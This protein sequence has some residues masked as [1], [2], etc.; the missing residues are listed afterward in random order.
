MRSTPTRAVWLTLALSVPI[1]AWADGI[2]SAIAENQNGFTLTAIHGPVDEDFTHNVVHGAD[3]PTTL[4]IAEVNGI[5]TSDRLKF[6]GASHHFNPPHGEGPNPNSF[7]MN[8][9]LNSGNYKGGVTRSTLQWAIMEHNGNGNR[10][11]DSYWLAYVVNVS[12]GVALND[13]DGYTVIVRGVHTSN[14]IF[15]PDYTFETFLSGA[16]QVPP[17]QS[18]A[19]GLAILETDPLF[20]T[21]RLSMAVSGLRVQDVTA[22]HIHQGASGQNGGVVF[23]LLGL[24]Q[25]FPVGDAGF[26]FVIES[27]ALPPHVN[28]LIRNR[29]AYINVH[30]ARFPGGEVR[31]D[32]VLTK[33]VRRV[34]R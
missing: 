17:V 21:M 3:W 11:W 30:T 28:N 31:G 14:Y 1:P 4:D 20:G 5:V 27:A 32:L 24:G 2:A 29:Q 23:D 25:R 34:A 8:S 15:N 16:R 6:T 10:H 33:V 26:G 19:Y 12:E 13:I 18:S 22:M 7:L 9:S